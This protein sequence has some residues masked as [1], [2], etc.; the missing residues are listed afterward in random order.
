MKG[1]LIDQKIF[2][3]MV[4][5]LMPDLMIKFKECNLDCSL[6]SIQWFVCLFCKTLN[7]TKE[8]I[9]I[10]FDNIIIQGSLALFKIG[11]ALLKWLKP[12][13]NKAKDFPNLLRILEEEFIGLN[14]GLRF[15]ELINEIHIDKKLLKLARYS[16]QTEDTIKSKPKGPILLDSMRKKIKESQKICNTELNYCLTQMEVSCLKEENR[17]SGYFYIFKQD[18][19]LIHKIDDYFVNESVVKST[20]KTKKMQ[21]SKKSEPFYIGDLT[22]LKDSLLIVRHEHICCTELTDGI[23]IKKN[24]GD[25]YNNYMDIL[26]ST[27]KETR[28]LMVSL[29]NSPNKI[30]NQTPS[31]QTPKNQTPKN[32]NKRNSS[33][34]FDF[35]ITEKKHDKSPNLKDGSLIFL[36]NQG[37]FDNI[38]EIIYE[39]YKIQLKESKSFIFNN[40]LLGFE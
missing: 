11:L 35:E 27:I 10:V 7:H 34:I 36:R 29:N 33:N 6:V 16:L 3:I 37:V 4:S 1:V 32:S 9:D 18:M 5:L 28:L 31:T 21:F 15:Q 25:S 30:T 2:G 26:Q 14:D 8:L 22:K 20:K 13:I 40:Y 17:V 39:K 19:R 12:A 38:D 23:L 24:K